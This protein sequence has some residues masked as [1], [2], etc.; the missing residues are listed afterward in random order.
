MLVTAE[1][2]NRN[3]VY[4]FPFLHNA[5]QPVIYSEVKLFV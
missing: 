3:K 1:N 4:D 5:N 2:E